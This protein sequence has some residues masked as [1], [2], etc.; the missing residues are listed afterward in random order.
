MYS[1]Y[2]IPGVKIGCATNVKRRIKQQGY[3][4]Y[5]LLEMHTDIYIASNRE[6]E[7]QKEY[8]Y[9]IDKVSYYKSYKQR[10]DTFDIKNC[11]KGG[12]IQGKR[13]VENG[14][15]H[16]ISNFYTRSKGGKIGI[17]K[18][19]REDKVKGAKIAG[20]ITGNKIHNCPHCNTDIKGRIYFRWHGD[21]C[22]YA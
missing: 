11:I 1:I 17:T 12:T 5:E 14:H 20:N 19:C 8:G 6:I 2:H 22:K 18:I 13:N 4:E 10:K 21:N 15:I 16:T 7:L 9:A 3:T